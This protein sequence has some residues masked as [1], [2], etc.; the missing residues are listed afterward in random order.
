MKTYKAWSVTRQFLASIMFVLLLVT[1]AMVWILSA[2]QQRVLMRQLE[3]KG[4]NN[5]AFLAAISA[6]PILSYNF[7]YL[8]NYVK[9]L[10]RPRGGVRGY[11]R[12]TGGAAHPA[13]QRSKG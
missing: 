9:D 5:A 11:R 13:R 1:V 3:E 12:Q 2:N 7:A 4:K 10:Q 8:E 6:E